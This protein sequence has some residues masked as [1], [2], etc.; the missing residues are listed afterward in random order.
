MGCGGR[1]RP[2]WTEVET[3]FARQVFFDLMELDSAL[4]CP[5]E[6]DKDCASAPAGPASAAPVE[7][8]KTVVVDLED[9]DSSLGEDA[10]ESDEPSACEA[11]C[12]GEDELEEE[13]QRGG[14]S[15]ALRGVVKQSSPNAMSAEEQERVQARA[16]QVR[17]QV[18]FNDVGHWPE[19]SHLWL[20]SPRLV[21]KRN[22][23]VSRLI[24]TLKD[25]CL[26]V[27]LPAAFIKGIPHFNDSM[28][29]LGQRWDVVRAFAS[30]KMHFLDLLKHKFEGEGFD[31]RRFFCTAFPSLQPASGGGPRI[32]CVVSGD[33]IWAVLR[34][35][36]KVETIPEFLKHLFNK[37]DGEARLIEEG[38]WMPLDDDCVRHPAFWK[39]QF[40]KTDASQRWLFERE[41]QDEE[42]TM[43]EVNW[44][45]DQ[46]GGQTLLIRRAGAASGAHKF[47]IRTGKVVAL[48]QMFYCGSEV[49]CTAYDIYKL[50]MDLPIFIH[51]RRRQPAVSRRLLDA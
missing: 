33:P 27:P 28:K 9:T 51:K 34:E 30:T 40:A 46:R 20:C 23:R 2:P 11:E 13:G 41:S 32:A 42:L 16:T 7:R 35:T 38:D 25:K 50:Y 37:H 1:P 39:S 47:E 29:H 5:V 36:W 26:S 43:E 18:H 44:V 19:D 22:W 6:E 24:D 17:R 15:G 10:Q 4:V 3:Q 49:E 48:A 31:S 21:A 12:S 45:L 8:A 14:A